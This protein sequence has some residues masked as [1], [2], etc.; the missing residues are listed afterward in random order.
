MGVICIRLDVR[1]FDML[2]K[3]EQ[4]IENVITN[5]TASASFKISEKYS[6]CLAS[7]SSRYQLD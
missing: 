4:S 5:V 1:K 7:R 2:S 3:S 6:S